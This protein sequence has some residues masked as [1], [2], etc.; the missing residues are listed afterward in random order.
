[1]KV[2]QHRLLGSVHCHDAIKITSKVYARYII[3][4]DRKSYQ[5]C[6]QRILSC[7]IVVGFI[8]LEVVHVLVMITGKRGS[9]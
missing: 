9:F 4:R 3:V 2:T 6:M 7:K 1:M 8:I 5:R